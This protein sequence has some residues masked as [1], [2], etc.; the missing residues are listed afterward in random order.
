VR[1]VVCIVYSVYV[2]FNEILLWMLQKQMSCGS[3]CNVF[4]V[5]GIEK[6]LTFQLGDR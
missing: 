3:V 6:F 4:Y 5:S 2:S 1:F